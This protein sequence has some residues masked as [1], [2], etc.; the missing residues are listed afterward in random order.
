MRFW[1]GAGW[2]GSILLS[3]CM[4]MP[5]GTST[6]IS[7]GPSAVSTS[8][9]WE[10]R[11]T[12]A[13]SKPASPEPR[14]AARPSR[15]EK[16]RSTP[17]VKAS[18]ADEGDTRVKVMPADP[19]EGVPLRE[20]NI[21][22]ST[23]PVS[24]SS[25]PK[26]TPVVASA[27]KPQPATAAEPA[28]TGSQRASKGQNDKDQDDT[29]DTWLD[30]YPNLSQDF[31]QYQDRIVALETE[32]KHYKRELASL[33]Q[34]VSKQWGSGNVLTSGKKQF[35]KY[36]DNYKSRGDMDFTG[37]KVV[38]ETVDQAD[39]KARLKEA[40]VTTLLTPL[41]ADDPNLFSDRRIDY[42]GPYLL[43]GQVK[44]QDGVPVKWPWRANRYAE[45]LVNHRVE[46]VEEDG[47]LVYRVEIPLIDNHVQV[48][49]HRYETLVRQAS[50][51]Y[52]ISEPLIYAIMETE[53]SFNPYATS[54]IPA[55]GLMQ[56]VPAT[57]GRDVF[58]RI[59]KRH[60]QPTRDYL[61]NPANNID[62]GTAYLSILRDNYLNKIRNPT[63]REYAMI[64]GYN[65]GAGN[66]LR[67]FSRNRTQAVEMIN[68]LSPEQVYQKLRH[69]H[70]SSEA[71][72]YLEKVTTAKRHYQSGGQGPALASAH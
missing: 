9:H 71:R 69:N 15:P 67:T 43:S 32:L 33:Q 44:D 29:Q 53:S 21:E 48:R 65:G 51:R 18:P 42:D 54:H 13:G 8:G 62:T 5:A 31:G 60:D 40:I 68:R 57:A 4:G 20:D 19:Q 59:K 70:P 14:P 10:T 41:N 49:G 6:H 16:P 38:V 72:R 55:Y 47:Q 24:E 63:A 28:I 45:W 17:E 58:Q 2:V 46:Q 66:V 3:G 22:G 23:P 34:Q 12:E 30:R 50:E 36:S 56:V 27:P 35:V 64:S 7:D 37:G 39:P 25:P 1:L 61:F 52:Q 11:S 26:P